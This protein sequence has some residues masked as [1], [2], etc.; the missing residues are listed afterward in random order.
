MAQKVCHLVLSHLHQMLTDFQNS[1]T[2]TV[3][4]EFAMEWLLKIL[5]HFKCVATLLCCLLLS[6]FFYTKCTKCGAAFRVRWDY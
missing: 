3:S 6:V 1:F 5:L 4:S 2:D